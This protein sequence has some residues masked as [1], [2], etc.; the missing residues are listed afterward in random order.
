[1]RVKCAEDTPDSG[2]CRGDD[3]RCTALYKERERAYSRLGTI[4]GRHHAGLLAREGTECVRVGEQ[5]EIR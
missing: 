1:M 5:L 3:F 2:C 4:V